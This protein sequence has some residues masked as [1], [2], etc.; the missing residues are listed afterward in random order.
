MFD[1]LRGADFTYTVTGSFAVVR[2]T[3]VAEP[4]LA[5]N[6]TTNANEAMD[7]LTNASYQIVIEGSSHREKLSPH[8][9]LLGDKGDG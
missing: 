1:K 8:R 9:K 5:T 2:R 7:C 4:R 3:P 6:Y